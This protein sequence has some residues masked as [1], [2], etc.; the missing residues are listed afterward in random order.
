[1]AVRAQ[2]FYRE[3]LDEVGDFAA[4]RAQDER[5]AR[6]AWLT[7]GAAVWGLSA[8]DYWIRP[9][10][11]LVETTSSRLTLGVPKVNRGGAVWRSILVPGAG[12]EFGN[13][14]TRSIVWLSAVLVSGAGYVVADY[15]VR[16]DDTDLTWAQTNVDS[17]GPSTIVQRQRE[18]D[19]AER[20]L[21][22]SK[23]IRTAFLIGIAGFHALN[24]VDAMIMYLSLPRRTSPR[25]PRSPR[26]CS[27]TAQA[28]VSPL[29]SDGRRL[30]RRSPHL[31]E[32][33]PRLA[34]ELQGVDGSFI[35]RIAASTLSR[36]HRCPEVTY[37]ESLVQNAPEPWHEPCCLA[38]CCVS[39]R[40]M[41]LS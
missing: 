19:Q 29:T 22:A 14:R 32:K 37:P 30:R 20:S 7:Y 36:G 3:R 33:M 23:D 1:M 25:C 34:R 13:H 15:K 5:Y 8:L 31:Q 18:L 2:I 40:I 39:R 26:S 4:D 41:P 10:L 17:A 11:S 21:D 12:Q 6:N 38:P 27:P 16:R 9:R 28:S 35:V 24:I